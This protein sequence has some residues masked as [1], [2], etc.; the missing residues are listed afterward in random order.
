[1]CIA[2]INVRQIEK[3]TAEPLVPDSNLSG[4]KIAIAKLKKYK[5]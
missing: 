5:L 2:V 4:I 1:M 3:D